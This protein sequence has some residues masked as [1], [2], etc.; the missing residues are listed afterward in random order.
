MEWRE[1]YWTLLEQRFGGDQVKI[2]DLVLSKFPRIHGKGFGIVVC[3]RRYRPGGG[4]KSKVHWL[5]TG[6]VSVTMSLIDLRKV[7]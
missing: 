1:G 2:G 6:E 7:A 4:P 3:T 5:E